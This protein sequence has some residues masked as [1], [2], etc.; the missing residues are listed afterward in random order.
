MKPNGNIKVFD[1][2]FYDEALLKI[3]ASK[4]CRI[5]ANHVKKLGYYG[6]YPIEMPRTRLSF[7]M[8]RN[9]RHMNSGCYFLRV[10]LLDTWDE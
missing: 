8:F 5:G 1:H 6:S 10:D 9:L 2:P 4:E 7:P 3:F